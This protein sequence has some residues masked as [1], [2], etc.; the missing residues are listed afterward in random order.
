MRQAF[1][2]KAEAMWLLFLT[3]VPAAIILFFA[4]VLPWLRQT[5]GW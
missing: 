3:L 5:F 1:T 2:F 4:L